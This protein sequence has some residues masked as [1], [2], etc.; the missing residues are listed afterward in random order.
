MGQCRV[1]RCSGAALA[2]FMFQNNG[3]SAEQRRYWSPLL[4][5]LCEHISESCYIV[6]VVVRLPL[7][8][9]CHFFK[10]DLPNKFSGTHSLCV[11]NTNLA[12]TV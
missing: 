10:A 3:F 8:L 2:L 5:P 4:L 12:Y 11:G 7:Y 9:C 1:M 6:V